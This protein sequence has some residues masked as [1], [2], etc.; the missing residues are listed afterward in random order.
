V[1]RRI[2]NPQNPVNAKNFTAKS[3][4]VR[5]G[6]L[7]KARQ[8]FQ[9][10]SFLVDSPGIIYYQQIRNGFVCTC[11]AAEK[12]EEVTNIITKVEPELSKFSDKVKLPTEISFSTLAKTPMFGIIPSDEGEEI[13]EEDRLLDDTETP[14]TP[15]F[16]NLFHKGVDCGICLRT[17]YTPLFNPVGR[18]FYA[19][20]TH[21]NPSLNH[22]RVDP[23]KSPHVFTCDNLR[24]A[25]VEFMVKIPKY[26]KSCSCA[27]YHNTEYLT[28]V[29]PS[30]GG[31][32]TV[33]ITEETLSGFRG[34]E[35]GL[36]IYGHTFT[37][38][39]L[40]FDLGI[41]IK[42]NFPQFSVSKDY[43][44]FFNL[45]QVTIELPPS[46]SNPQV[47]DLIYVPEWNRVFMCFDVQPKYEGPLQTTL[48]GTAIQG[49]LVQVVETAR[50][51]SHLKT[52]NKK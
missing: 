39:F 24:G 38:I 36:R 5:R 3:A 37:H 22:Y 40:E 23:L 25:Y 34:K 45:Q 28:G 50:L 16:S 41:D 29:L 8:N 48:L 33:P 1:I 47:N 13:D 31:N 14:G 30:I 21:S 42:A 27:V 43:S 44:Y 51:V 26:Y 4:E 11:H 18:Q 9:Q 6:E 19:L 46:V 12:P 15:L 2:G 32:N 52:L 10:N 49:R 17:G 20:T 35:V 7:Q